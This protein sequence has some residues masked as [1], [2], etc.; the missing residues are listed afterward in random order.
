MAKKVADMLWISKGSAIVWLAG[1]AVLASAVSGPARAQFSDRYDMLKAIDE[2][3]YEEVRELMGKCRCPNT[4]NVDGEPALLLAARSGSLKITEFILN[5]G[6]NPN[7]RSRVDGATALMVFARR[8]NVA[9]VEM[10]L[11]RGG[12][13]NVA[14]NTGETSLIHAVRGRARRALPLLLGKGANPDLAN[15]QGQTAMEIAQRNRY[16]MMERLLADAAAG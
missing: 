6:A 10:L 9:G 8:D 11:E 15:Y 16:R 1:L 14:D 5:E 4:R 12:D 13:P 2:Q 7:A 3:N